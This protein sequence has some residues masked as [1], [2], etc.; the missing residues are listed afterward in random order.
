MSPAELWRPT[1]EDCTRLAAVYAA[2]AAA[3]RAAGDVAGADARDRVAAE[4]RR[5]AGRGRQEG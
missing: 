5:R 1:G 2:R 4:L 3:R